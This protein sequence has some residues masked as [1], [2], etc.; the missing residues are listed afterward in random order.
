[1]MYVVDASLAVKWYVPEV[2]SDDAGRLLDPAYQL[3]APDLIIP[4][5]G[6]IIRKKIAR[7]ELTEAQGRKIIGAFL[8][9]PVTVYSAVPLLKP[10]FEGAVRSAQTVYDWTYLALA[11]ALDC[12]MV[13]ADERF[14][15]ALSR[16]RLARHL[17]WA[18]DIP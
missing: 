16:N 9:V 2:H 14:Y 10:A 17:L 1:M 12:R 15:R 4:E 8:I 11:V 6:N 3:C 18:A 5:F 7:G 13:T